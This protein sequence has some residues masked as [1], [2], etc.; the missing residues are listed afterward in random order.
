MSGNNHRDP[1]PENFKSLEEFWEF[2]DTHSS[3]AYEDL[4]EDVDVQVDLSRSKR[5]F[6][7]GKILNE[8]KFK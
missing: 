7:V 4:M 3:A 6:P 1:L 2:W 5:Y 8:F